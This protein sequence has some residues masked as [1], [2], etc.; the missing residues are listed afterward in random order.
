MNTRLAGGRVG[1]VYALHHS[2]FMKAPQLNIWNIQ[3]NLRIGLGLSFLVAICS[4]SSLQQVGQT[5]VEPT[6]NVAERSLLE[7]NFDEA[8][9]ISPQNAEVGGL[10]K[11]AADSIE[12][13]KKDREGKPV[14][15]RAKGHVFVEMALAERASGL[16][17]EAILTRSEVTL[18]GKPMVKRGNR[19]ALSKDAKTTFWITEQRLNASGRCELAKLEEMP[20]P[21]IVASADFFPVAEPMLPPTT[22]PWVASS[23]NVLLPA[24]QEEVP[25]AATPALLT[26][27][28]EN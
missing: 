8:K 13:L 24:L 28:T 23:E 19:V 10:F 20:A 3:T 5:T 14:K 1:D 9:A 4:C 22:T 2:R 16:C 17:E 11:V 27:S 21:V 18:T 15:V 26:N 7:M 6:V 12:V 25:I